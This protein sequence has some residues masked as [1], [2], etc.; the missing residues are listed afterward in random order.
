MWKTAHFLNVPSKHY[1]MWKLHSPLLQEWNPAV[2]GILLTVTSPCPS[3]CECRSIYIRFSELQIVTQHKS[4]LSALS[5][6]IVKK[7]L[8]LSIP[9]RLPDATIPYPVASVGYF[10]CTH[11]FGSLFGKSL[12]HPAETWNAKEINDLRQL[13]TWDVPSVLT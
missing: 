13:T 12:Y 10:G 9:H 8:K 3:P 5:T 11:D 7:K 2:A 4:S 1:D 6:R